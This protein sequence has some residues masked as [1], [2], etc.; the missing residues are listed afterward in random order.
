MKNMSF[1]LTVPQMIAR[2]K[3]VTR[4]LGWGNLV[5]GDLIMACVKCQGLGKDGA[6]ERIG[7]IEITNIRKEHLCHI[8][9]HDCI[10]EGF[11]DMSPDEFVA[12]F[13]SH[14]NCPANA[15]VTR[16]EFK[17]VLF[18][19]SVDRSKFSPSQLNWWLSQQTKTATL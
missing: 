6:I 19:D 7:V 8:T 2:S 11:P 17:H 13:S 18:H 9:Y 15:T 3:T 10:Q 16:I 14:N 4:R 12:F 5:S 1:L